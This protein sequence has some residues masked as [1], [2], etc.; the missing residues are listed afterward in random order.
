MPDD[1]EI[2]WTEQLV[3]VQPVSERAAEWLQSVLPLKSRWLVRYVNRDDIA[4]L[5]EAAQ[6]QGLAIGGIKMPH[7]VSI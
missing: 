2:L 6:Q 1:L 5:A 3:M 7:E 4:E